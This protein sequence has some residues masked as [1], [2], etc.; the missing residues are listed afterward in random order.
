[1][2]KFRIAILLAIG[3]AICS[4]NVQGLK[5]MGSDSRNEQDKPAEWSKGNFN[6]LVGWVIR[7]IEFVGNA[8]TP[9]RVVRR[10]CQLKEGNPFTVKGLGNSI[11]H[12]NR[13]KTLETVT[14]RNFAWRKVD[15]ANRSQTH[16]VDLVIVVRER[17]RTR[18]NLRRH[19]LTNRR[20]GREF[21]P[22]FPEKLSTRRLS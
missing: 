5:G 9:D 17:P 12:L 6:A 2:L 10:A 3:L 15:A 20:S 16:E 22:P 11:T 13:L 4:V 8:T 1:M 14:A 19:Q 18:L 7:R 21:R